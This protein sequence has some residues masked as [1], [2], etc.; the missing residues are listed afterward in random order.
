MKL[1]WILLLA[2][3]ALGASACSGDSDEKELTLAPES[4]LPDF[5]R[6][7]PAQVR[8]AYRFAIANPDIVELFP[9]FCGC[10]GVG[11]MSNLDCYVKEFRAD[12]S[13]VFDD[14]AY[15]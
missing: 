3:L 8:E 2:L 11:H 14:H 12:G 9:C 5:V 15:G 6:G 4:A 13:I 10:G 7:A 1:R